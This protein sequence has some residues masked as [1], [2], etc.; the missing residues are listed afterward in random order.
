MN[1]VRTAW[2]EELGI[3]CIAVLSI[4]LSQSVRYHLGL[5][6]E[7]PTTDLIQTDWYRRNACGNTIASQYGFTL[8]LVSHYLPVMTTPADDLSA[9]CLF[10][11]VGASINACYTIPRAQLA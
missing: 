6:A 8:C 1:A 9:I 4:R 10:L 3:V 5:G 7:L 11:T 2:H